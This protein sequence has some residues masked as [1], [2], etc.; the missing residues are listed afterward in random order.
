VAFK[1]FQIE[2]LDHHVWGNVKRS[3]IGT[4]VNRRYRRT[5]SSAANDS[6]TQD[7]IDRAVKEIFKRLNAYVVAK[8]GHFYYSY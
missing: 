1:F 2:P 8:G 7:T 5:Q 6:L 4:L 3:I